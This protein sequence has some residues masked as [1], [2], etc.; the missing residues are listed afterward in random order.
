MVVAG[1]YVHVAVVVPLQMPPQVV[2]KPA[3]TVRVPCGGPETGVQLPTALLTSQASH[4]PVHA[5]SQHT[6]STQLL[7]AHVLPVEHGTP[8][9]L[10]AGRRSG[11]GIASTSSPTDRSSSPVSG[12]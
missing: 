5:L 11:A 3:Q 2:P 12:F 4:W 1:G 9:A 10:G 8:L 7:L 6:P